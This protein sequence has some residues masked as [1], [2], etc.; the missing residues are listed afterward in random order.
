MVE[1]PVN[2]VSNIHAH[3]LPSSARAVFD[4]SFYILPSVTILSIFAGGADLHRRAGFLFDSCPV[5]REAHEVLQLTSSAWNT[6]HISIS[7]NQP[8]LGHDQTHQ[9]QQEVSCPSAQGLLLVGLLPGLWP[10]PG[11]AE[12]QPSV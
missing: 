8:G 9:T 6:L 10:F 5:Y 3:F 7:Q 4:L 2:L 11:R 12:T 1:V